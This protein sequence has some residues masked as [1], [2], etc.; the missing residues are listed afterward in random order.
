[1]IESRHVRSGNKPARNGSATV[2]NWTSAGNRLRISVESSAR[3]LL[4]MNKRG[5]SMKSNTAIGI[6]VAAALLVFTPLITPPAAHGQQV[7]AA[8]T[9][10]VTDPSG[11]AVSEAKVTATDIDR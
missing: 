8:I 9:G 1:M 10:K 5:V 11:A 2:V 7:M 3:G 4:R 6:G